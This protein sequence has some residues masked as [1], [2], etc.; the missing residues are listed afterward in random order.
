MILPQELFH[1]FVTGEHEDKVEGLEV[2]VILTL[3]CRAAWD[4]K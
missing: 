3:F 2:I 1:L 4:E